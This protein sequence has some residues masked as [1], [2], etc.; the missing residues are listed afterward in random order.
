MEETQGTSG[1]GNAYLRFMS[2]VADH[3]QVY[4]PLLP[5]FAQWVSTALSGG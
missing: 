1:F 4:Q 3:I 5:F 2:V